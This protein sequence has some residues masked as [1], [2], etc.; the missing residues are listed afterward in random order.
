MKKFIKT[1]ILAA[2]AAFVSQVAQ[3]QFAANDL[4]LGFVGVGSTSNYVINLGTASSITSSSTVVDL[5]SDFSLSVYQAVFTGASSVSMGVVAGQAQFP[6]S[7]DLFATTVRGGGAGDPAV[8]GSDLSSIGHNQSTIS[9][10]VSDLSRVGFSAGAGSSALLG[11]GDNNSWSLNVS[12]TF[13]ASSFYGATGIDPMTALN[14][15]IAYE[16]LWM[17]TPN[18]AYAY[19]GYFT[20][21]A[22]NSTLTYTPSVAPVPE[23]TTLS[24][25]AGGALLIGSMG[26]RKMRRSA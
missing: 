21:D 26:W 10:A 14:S 16:D 22:N 3:A 13:T 4:Y 24:L 19:L 2:C 15:G 5:S 8:A 6:S 20:I 18:S 23:P 25:V 11:A 1:G 7:Y 9:S 12:P 17:A